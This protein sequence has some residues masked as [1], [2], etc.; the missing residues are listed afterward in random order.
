MKLAILG[1]SACFI[2]AGCE[3]RSSNAEEY[4]P[5]N[6][7][8]AGGP[9]VTYDPAPPATIPGP[10]PVID[11]ASPPIVPWQEPGAADV[12]PARRSKTHTVARGETLGGISQKYYGTTKKWSKIADANGNLDPRKL[13][14]GMK[15]IIP[16]V[17]E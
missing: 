12:T 13:R 10:A 14:I 17:A 7:P 6:D 1:L 11:T 9:P 4:R 3:L 15:L 2:I 5:A 16:D 8:Y